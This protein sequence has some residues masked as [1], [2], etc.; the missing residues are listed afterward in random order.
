MITL[1]D[2]GARRCSARR[3]RSPR[4]MTWPPP[5]ARLRHSGLRHQGR[6]QRRLLFAHLSP[7]S[8]TSRRSR[9]TTAPTWSPAAHQAQGSARRRD[10]RHRRNHH[11]RHPPARHGQ[12]RRAALPDHRGQRRGH[13]AP[14]RQPLRHRPEHARRHHPRHQHPAGRHERRRRRLRLVRTRRGQPRARHG[15]QRHRHRDRSDEGARSR[16]GRLPRDVDDR[17]RQDRRCLHHRHRQQERHRQGSL[18]EDE[19]RRDPLQLRPLQRRDRPRSAGQGRFVAAPD[20]RVRRRV[21]ACATAARST[22][23]A[24]AA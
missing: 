6:E 11:R 2:G 9:W 15:R 19:G 5:G 22:C 16:D 18:R 23:W 7:R 10:R 3:I 14:V 8:I 17:S 4:R 1:R 24:K 21:R 13:Q 20:A 12:G